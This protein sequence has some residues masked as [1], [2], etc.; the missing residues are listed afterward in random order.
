MVKIILKAKKSVN[1]NIMFKITDQD[2]DAQF[3]TAKVRCTGHVFG[4]DPKEL[5][6]INDEGLAV[7]TV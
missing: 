5:K 1:A 2:G 4:V 7:R 6:H 3:L